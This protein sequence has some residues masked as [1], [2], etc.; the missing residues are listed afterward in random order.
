MNL[1]HSEA[2]KKESANVTVNTINT[3]DECK[4]CE[5][6]VVT[7]ESFRSFFFFLYFQGT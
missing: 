6:N 1:G 7:G 5:R 3:N 2:N 4:D